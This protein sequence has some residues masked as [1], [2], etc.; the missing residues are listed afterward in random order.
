M[1]TSTLEDFPIE[2]ELSEDTMILPF[3]GMNTT[4]V[5]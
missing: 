1:H 5:V 3:F 4:V 2:E